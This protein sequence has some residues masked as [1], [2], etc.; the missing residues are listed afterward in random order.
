MYIPFTIS[1]N[2]LCLKKKVFWMIL[3]WILAKMFRDLIKWPK[4]HHS[5]ICMDVWMCYSISIA[6]ALE[7]LRSCTKPSIWS[8][9]FVFVS[10]SVMCGQRW[11]FVLTNLYLSLYQPLVESSI[12]CQVQHVPWNMHTVLLC[13]VVFCCSAHWIPLVRWPIFFR[14]TDKIIWLPQFQ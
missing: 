1:K 10:S 14:I 6:N 4:Y 12:I 5:M 7:I 3:F 11:R 9:L 8:F 2:Q 13:C